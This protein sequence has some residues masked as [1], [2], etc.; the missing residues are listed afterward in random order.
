MISPKNVVLYEAMKRYFKNLWYALIGIDP[1]KEELKRLRDQ[2][3]KA[4]NNVRRLQVLY[5]KSLEEFEKT[6]TAVEDY[7][8]IMEGLR[9]RIAEKDK[10]LSEFREM[11]KKKKAEASA[12]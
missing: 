7:Q 9:E 4:A 8:N 1:F 10:M 11:M 3:E 5:D 12:S 6:E 2:Y